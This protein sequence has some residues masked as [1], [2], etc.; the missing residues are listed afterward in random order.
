[1][2]GLFQRLNGQVRWSLGCSGD[3]GNN[4]IVAAELLAV[5][6]STAG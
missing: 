2:R 6:V 3:D 5:L 4:G 1:M